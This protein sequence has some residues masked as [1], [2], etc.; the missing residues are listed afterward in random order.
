[1]AP[2]N[3]T[4]CGSKSLQ[5]RVY[6]AVGIQMVGFKTYLTQLM[7]RLGIEMTP[8]TEKFLDTVYNSK[9]AHH[10]LHSSL[11][12]KRKRSEQTQ[13]QLRELIQQAEKK[14]RK[15]SFY[16]PGEGF[17][18]CIPLDFTNRCAACGGPDHKSR[19]SQ[20]CTQSIQRLREEAEKRYSDQQ[21]LVSVRMKELEDLED[22]NNIN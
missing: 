19:Q 17:N 13:S 16:C 12:Y 1:M 5:G 15:N 11:D 8:G 2:K 10:T 4:Y 20:R 18:S 21:Q 9:S 22:N 6:L 7:M 14:R 3:K